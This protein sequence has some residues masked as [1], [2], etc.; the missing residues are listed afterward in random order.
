MPGD[1]WMWIDLSCGLCLDSVAGL[2]AQSMIRGE[3]ETAEFCASGPDREPRNNYAF[4]EHEAQCDDPSSLRSLGLCEMLFC[5][6]PSGVPVHGAGRKCRQADRD[7]LGAFRLRRGIT[8]PLPG[9]GDHGLAGPNVHGAAPVLHA[10]HPAQHDSVLVEL[11]SLSR[12]LPPARAP[13]VGNA[14]I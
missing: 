8:D 12:L 11:R 3:G 14:E 5:C 9:A 2:K 1:L 4:L 6:S 13:H 7:V 10:Q